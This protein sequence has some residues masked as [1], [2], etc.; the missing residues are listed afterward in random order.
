M[1]IVDN[2]SRAEIEQSGDL[3]ARLKR[4]LYLPI[5]VY[6]V[7]YAVALGVSVAL[8]FI[9]V[10]APLWLDETVSFYTISAGL[11]HISAREGGLSSPP[12]FYILWF[13]T[14]MLGTSEIALR[15]PEILATLGAAYFLYR[16]ARE[17]FDREAALITTVL[18]CIHPIVVFGSIDV[19]PYAF[20][21]LVE[22]A[23]IFLLCRLRNDNSS[24]L[25]A[26]FGVM[27]AAIL[28]FRVLFIAV[29]PA[30]TVCFVLFK[31]NDRKTLWRQGAV[32]VGA[33]TLTFLPLVPMLAYML[34]TG[35]SHSFAGAPGFADVFWTLAPGWLAVIMGATHL[36]AAHWRRLSPRRSEPRSGLCCAS[37]ALIPVLILFV[38]SVAT[39]LRIFV[40]RY[41]LVAIPGIALC[42]GFMINRVDSRILR[43]LFCIAVLAAASYQYLSSPLASHHGYTWKYALE[44]AQENAAVDNA[45]LL[46]CSDF[47]E[48]DYERMPLV[49]AKDSILFTQLSY[50]KVTVPVVPLPRAVNQE[51]I[52]VA[53]NFLQDP[54][55]A[56]G[57]FLALG[58]SPSYS[59]LQWLSGTTSTTH[60]SRVLGIF[61]GVEVVE[62][63]PRT[64]ARSLH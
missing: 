31:T 11:S 40:E 49:S 10:R 43:A 44:L 29:M 55:H 45:P 63:I 62:F 30:L 25:A 24:R 4:L 22:N 7:M 37:L 17:L 9:A 28:Y 48:A 3:Q 13:A 60:Y 18:F 14:K 2:L 50:Y 51:M 15:V 33:F 56:H 34:R 6:H 54:A 53:S 20:A 26:L 35:E 16:A 57:R 39:P 59:T 32:A 19:R 5:D 36:A 8:W 38:V 21:V 61:D 64:H 42:W 47:H 41:R 46:I 12:F 52:R 23:A 27:A 1:G 58:Y